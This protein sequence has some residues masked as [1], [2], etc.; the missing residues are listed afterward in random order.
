[1]I[2]GGNRQGAI[3]LLKVVGTGLTETSDVA[4]NDLN[5]LAG[6]LNELGSPTRQ[7]TAYN[8]STGWL[9]Q[10][11]YLLKN[12]GKAIDSVEMGDSSVKVYWKDKRPS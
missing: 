1:M 8:V 6:L 9:S 5:E 7:F 10:C 4:R 11:E 2:K 3:E 12:A